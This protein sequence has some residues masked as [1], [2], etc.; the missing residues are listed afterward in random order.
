LNEEKQSELETEGE[1]NMPGLETDN[2]INK[3][4]ENAL[5]GGGAG[6]ATGG[7][8]PRSNTPAQ[9]VE[10]TSKTTVAVGVT[11]DMAESRK[12][13]LDVTALT[14]VTAE[15]ISVPAPAKLTELLA[16]RFKQDGTIAETK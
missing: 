16:A 6:G 7:T 11:F 12:F 4:S 15:L 9:P 1:L 2:L 8:A 5:G 3:G 13:S 14:E 10:K